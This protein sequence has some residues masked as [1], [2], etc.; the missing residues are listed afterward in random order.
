MVRRQNRQGEFVL[1]EVCFVLSGLIIK[2]LILEAIIDKSVCFTL[3]FRI[4]MQITVALSLQ[5]ETTNANLV[6]QVKLV[7]TYTLLIDK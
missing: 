5:R 3:P 4:S 6:L 7:S 1:V 2:S